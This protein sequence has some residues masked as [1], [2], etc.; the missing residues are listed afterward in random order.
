MKAWRVTTKAVAGSPAAF[1]GR[2]KETKVFRRLREEIERIA[3]SLAI[4]GPDDQT[5]FNTWGIDLVCSEHECCVAV[6]GK[7]KTMRDGAVPDNRKAAFFDLYRLEQYIASG[8]YMAGVFLWLT[9]HP[10]Y[11]QVGNGDS[12]DFSTHDG[13]QY[14]GGT[15]LR[16][17]RARNAMPM[18][19]ILRSDFVFRW[20]PVDIVGGWFSLGL[21][22]TNT[23]PNKALEPSALI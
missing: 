2:D 11:R 23:Q 9:D 4:S 1:L 22:V 16:A 10:A 13:R 7:Y 21:T 6:E 19:L 20:E 3:P 12:A 15:P 14:R 5:R 17:L 18:P 8:K